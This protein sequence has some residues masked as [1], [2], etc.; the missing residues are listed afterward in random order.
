MSE[1]ES[2]KLFHKIIEGNSIFENENLNK[3]LMLNFVRVESRMGV[4]L[5]GM[6]FL[7]Y[8]FIFY[9]KRIWSVHIVLLVEF[10]NRLLIVI[11]SGRK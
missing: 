1:L 3:A 9:R 4:I 2:L 11:P 5:A 10:N 6:K 7:L 8:Y